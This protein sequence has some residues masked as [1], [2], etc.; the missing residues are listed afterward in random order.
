MAERMETNIVRF[1][2]AWNGFNKQ[3]VT[4]YLVKTNGA[5]REALTR[6]NDRVAELE[7]ENEALRQTAPDTQRVE[8]LES[9]NMK[10]MERIRLLEDQLAEAEKALA[11]ADSQAPGAPVA[12]AVPAAASGDEIRVLELE[13]YR[14]AEAMERRASLRFQQVSQQVGQISGSIVKELTSTVDSARVALDAIDDQLN[15]L[16]G[17]SRQLDTAMADGVEKLETMATDY[18]ELNGL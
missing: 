18:A 17:A 15:V 6:L 16:Q 8:E 11:E 7:S 13:A 14:R 4:E 2:T 3:D 1:R 5:H 10:L 9:Y 12:A